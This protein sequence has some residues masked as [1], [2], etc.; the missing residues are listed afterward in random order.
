VH[1]TEANRRGRDY[2]GRGVHVAARI[3]ALA[4]GGQ[5]IASAETAEAAGPFGTSEPRSVGLRGIAD[6]LDVVAI[7]WT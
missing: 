7:S 6:E 1:A 2:G 3:A 4:E 5:I